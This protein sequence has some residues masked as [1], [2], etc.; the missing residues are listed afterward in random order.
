M[1]T[2][3]QP[4][5]AWPSLANSWPEPFVVPSQARWRFSVGDPPGCR[6]HIAPPIGEDKGPTALPR[7]GSPVD[8]RAVVPAPYCDCVELNLP[9]GRRLE[10]H[11]DPDPNG[12]PLVFHHGT[13]GTGRPLP[14]LLDAARSN[15]LRWVGITRPGFGRSSP[16]PG[17]QVIDIATDTGAA[18]DLL[19]I[20]RCFVAG[21]S[22]GGPH[23]LACG[24]ALPRQVTEVLVIAGSA[25]YPV[26]GL[27]WFAGMAPEDQ[28]QALAAL[29]G[30]ETL[31]ELLTPRAAWYAHASGDDFVGA[32]IG[33]FSESDVAAV[34]PFANELVAHFAE[35]VSGTGWIDD[36]LALVRPWG[37]DLNA[38]ST[39]TTFCHGDLDRSC[40]LAH[41]QW[42]AERI[43]GARIIVCPGEG[44]LSI[45]F[46]DPQKLL[47]IFRPLRPPSGQ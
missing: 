11:L 3:V 2:G 23:A 43:R 5:S 6:C 10:V 19:G 46:H 39:P 34:A 29:A 45:G 40:P 28:A 18:L 22:G 31:R 27:D 30:A 35:A 24:A 33:R 38:V 17:R 47:A 1:T 20:D 26:V 41:A 12:F 37:F 36:W 16:L 25:P 42:M 21:W 7:S 44:H 14:I 13:P 32:I 9:D 15:G 8:H 4:S